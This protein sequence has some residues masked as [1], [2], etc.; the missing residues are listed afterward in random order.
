[1]RLTLRTLLAYMDDI[2]EPNDHEDLGQKIEASDFA[3]E[4]IHRSRD[5]VRRLRLGAPAV[6]ASGS[7]DVLDTV[8]LGD[9]NS[10]AEYLDNTLPPEQVADFERMCLEPG[11]EPDMHLAEVASCHH[12]LTMVLGEPADVDADL[13]TRDVSIAQPNRQRTEAANRSGACRSRRCSATA[14]Q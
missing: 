12:V 4:L 3:A 13:K 7:D 6:L 14:T 11:T 8:D 5:A 2:L 9:A 10:V 1:M